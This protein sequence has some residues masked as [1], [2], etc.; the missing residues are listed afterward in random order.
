MTVDPINKCLT[1]WLEKQSSGQPSFKFHHIWN[2]ARGVFIVAEEPQT[3]DELMTEQTRD[4]K[5]PKRK[6]QMAK[7]QFSDQKSKEKKQNI[8]NGI[9]TQDKGKV[10]LPN[11]SM[12]ISPICNAVTSP[13]SKESRKKAHRSEER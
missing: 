3:K 6:R 7:V 1:S 10:R 13:Y 2:E 12:D 9:P 8:R 4:S 11:F 5:A